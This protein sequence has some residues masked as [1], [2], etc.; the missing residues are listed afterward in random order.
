MSRTFAEIEQRLLAAGF[1]KPNYIVGDVDTR[2]VQIMPLVDDGNG[3]FLPVATGALAHNEVR[4][5]VGTVSLAR[6]LSLALS[7]ARS[8]PRAKL[9]PRVYRARAGH[10]HL[11]VAP[12]L[13]G[14]QRL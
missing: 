2:L 6:A 4:G 5:E 10:V 14:G 1:S 8:F 11:R 9:K 13:H 12:G 3:C 7:L